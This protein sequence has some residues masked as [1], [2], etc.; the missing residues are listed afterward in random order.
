M[1]SMTKIKDECLFCSKRICN[2]R[3]V[4]TEEP[5]YD[6]VACYQHIE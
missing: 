5:Q 1:K 4:R 2:T 6:E 3:I